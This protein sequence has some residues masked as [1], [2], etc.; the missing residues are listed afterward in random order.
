MNKIM[1]YVIIF[2]VILTLIVLGK[3]LYVK[4]STKKQIIEPKEVSKLEDIDCIVVLGAGVWGDKPSPML[5]D[6][7][8]RYNTC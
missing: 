1:I 7:F 2:L 6:R 8:R 5:E 3:S 4:L